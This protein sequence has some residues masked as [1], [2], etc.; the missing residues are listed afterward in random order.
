[1]EEVTG[2][3]HVRLI[4]S[5]KP[6]R[7]GFDEV[8]SH[9]KFL[10]NL[11]EVGDIRGETTGRGRAMGDTTFDWNTATADAAPVARA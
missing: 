6:L 1:M 3:R 4:Q 10:S 9:T 7:K 5:R 8:R 11:I 2:R